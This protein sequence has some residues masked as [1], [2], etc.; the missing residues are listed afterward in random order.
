M[1]TQSKL[2]FPEVTFA[3]PK[4]SRNSS[5]LPFAVCNCSP[6]TGFDPKDLHRLLERVG[7]PSGMDDQDCG[8]GWLEGLNKVYIPSLACGDAPAGMT[9]ISRIRF[10][11]L[12]GTIQELGS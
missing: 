5:I 8:S 6:P 2:F 7:S 9:P 10:L 1:Y 11:K 4:S 3:K 12:L